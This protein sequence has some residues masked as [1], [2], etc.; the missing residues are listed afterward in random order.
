[1]Q[2]ST[3]T[4][5]ILVTGAALVA[6]GAFATALGEETASHAT[7]TPTMLSSK[8]TL[9]ETATTTTNPPSA[10]VTSVAEPVLKADIPCGFTSGC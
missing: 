1:M 9:G 3:K 8:M 6:A 7:P 2:Y 5:A 10:P 4:R